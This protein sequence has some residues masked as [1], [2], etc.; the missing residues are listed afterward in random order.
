MTQIKVMLSEAPTGV[1]VSFTLDLGLPRT[2]L[3]PLHPRF[4]RNEKARRF[5]SMFRHSQ[6]FEVFIQVGREGAG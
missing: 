5:L 2:A 3:S 4:R 6:M 1:L